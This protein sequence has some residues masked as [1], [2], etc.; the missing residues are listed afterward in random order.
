MDF[1]ET[2]KKKQKRTPFDRSTEMHYFLDNAGILSNV[3]YFSRYARVNNPFDI[4]RANII[5]RALQN[6]EMIQEALTKVYRKGSEDEKKNMKDTLS[7]FLETL[8]YLREGKDRIFVPIFP[9]STNRIYDG[10]FDK[11]KEKP[12][13]AL[14]SDYAEAFVTDPFDA[15]GYEL[16][17][18]YFTKWILICKNEKEAVFYDYDSWSLYAVNSQG[19]LNAQ[20]ALFDRYIGRPY[21]NHMIERVTPVAEAYLNG[22]KE[23]MID[24]LV[25]NQ[26]ISRRLIFKIY[27]EERRV[28]SRINK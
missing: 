1:F 9:R 26:L 27:A 21:T 28:Y 22:N 7:P 5:I 15:Y 23:T 11:L 8:P 6:K 13:S 4:V 3:P 25:D 10:E 19:R 12:Y 2:L 17:N 18:S 20:I 14:L 24:E 16:Y